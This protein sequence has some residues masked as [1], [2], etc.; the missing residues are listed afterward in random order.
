LNRE[1]GMNEKTLTVQTTASDDLC[2]GMTNPRNLNHVLFRLLPGSHFRDS[3]F[4][5]SSPSKKIQLTLGKIFLTPR[6]TEALENSAQD[7]KEFIDRH[8][9]GDWGDVN[10]FDRERNDEAVAN[11]L[12]V[13]SV[14]LTK[15][16]DKIWIITEA[17]RSVTTILLPHEY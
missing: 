13:L 6:A 1:C 14:Y 5:M 7:P 12:R 2:E 17:N 16:D 15:A 4:F 9:Q 10:A 11:D 8:K 3:I